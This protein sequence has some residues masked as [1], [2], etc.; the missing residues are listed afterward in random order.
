MRRERR[1]TGLSRRVSSRLLCAAVLACPVFTGAAA[2]EGKEDQIEARVFKN[3]NGDT[4]PY[5]I[6]KPA[7]Y[8]PKTRYPLVLCLHGAGG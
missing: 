7:G 5:R 4:M 2:K 6:L 3:E 1:M 8:D